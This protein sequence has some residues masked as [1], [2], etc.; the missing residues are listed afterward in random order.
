MVTAA[1]AWAKVLAQGPSKAKAMPARPTP[2]RAI[3]MNADFL[4]NGAVHGWVG[5]A[6]AGRPVGTREA[7]TV[8]AREVAARAAAAARARLRSVLH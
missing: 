8:A 2:T 1:C 5:A 7:G 6:G 4:E 3:D